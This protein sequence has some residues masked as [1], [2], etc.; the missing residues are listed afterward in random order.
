MNLRLKSLELRWVGKQDKGIP[1]PNITFQKI[2][3]SGIYI[4]PTKE[5]FINDSLIEAKNGLI[6]ISDK[7]HEYHD[8]IIAH[9][10]NWV[11]YEYYV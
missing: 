2:P 6:V 11:G 9:E 7:L 3:Y 8:S 10:W 1:Y 4:A 5:Y